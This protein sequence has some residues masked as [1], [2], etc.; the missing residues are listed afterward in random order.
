[1][2]KPRVY[3]F[4]VRMGK[5]IEMIFRLLVYV[6]SKSVHWY[7]SSSTDSELKVDRM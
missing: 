5:F 4:D 3:K 7:L 2:Y 1:M 6:V